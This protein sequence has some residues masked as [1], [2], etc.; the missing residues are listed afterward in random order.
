MS[1]I[2]LACAIFAEII[3]TT[4]MKLSNGL[5]QLVPTICM[6]I[7]YIISFA[8]LSLALKEIEVS[9][10]YAIWSAVGIVLISL[11]GIFFFQESAHISKIIFIIIII[12]GVVGL[13]LS[14][15]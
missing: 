3:G 1:W 10:A 2:Y 4:M 6:F 13:K 8:L 15:N 11:I 9:I 7:S 5:T 12:T 14:T